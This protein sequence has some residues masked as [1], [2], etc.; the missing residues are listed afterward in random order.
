LL[1]AVD[2]ALA[3]AAPRGSLSPKGKF[4]REHLRLLTDKLAYSTGE[5]EKTSERLS[6]AERQEQRIRLLLDSTAEAIYGL[7]VHGHGTFC[8]RTCVR[9]LGYNEPGELLGKN[10][11]ALIHHTRPDGTPY[12]QHEC[13]IFHSVRTGEAAH[14]EGEVFWRADGSS[15]PVEYWAYPVRHDERVVGA[16]VTFLDV[17]K[18]KQ[19]QDQFRREQK[20]EL[21]VELA[22]QVAHNFS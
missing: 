18:R 2:A 12:P 14:V 11:H 1:T 13:P 16:V 10:T 22:G 3:G 8:N 5:L 9:L 19:V 17:S 4:D 21:I 15:F 7:D 20:M 6:A